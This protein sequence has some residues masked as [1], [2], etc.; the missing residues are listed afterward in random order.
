MEHL[1]EPRER[2]AHDELGHTEV[3]PGVARVLVGV[4]VATLV[5]VFAVDAPR[6]PSFGSLLAE[7][8]NDC[9]LQAFERRLEDE[10][11]LASRL[12]PHVQAALALLGAGNEQT[13][14]GRDGWL[15][16]RAGFDYATGPGFL[17]PARMRARVEDADT[18]AST[19]AP[20]PV[21]AIASL[22]EQLAER[23][24]ALIVMPTPVKAVVHPERL[25]A[26]YDAQAAAVQ[27]PSWPAFV[28]ALAERG[29]EVFDP[30]PLLAAADSYLATDTHW[31]ADAMARVARALTAEIEE[32]VEFA[33]PPSSFAQS[34]D[35]VEN[36]G[37]LT[38]MLSLPE[39]QTR[40][41]PERV[42]TAPVT[43]SPGADAGAA[44]VLLLGDSFSNVYSSR[45]A[46]AQQVDGAALDWGESAGL[47]EQ[48]AFAL[49]RPVDRIVR[50]AG[51]SHATRDA[52][53]R[54]VARA[55]GEG[56]DRL[57]DVRVV[58]YQFAMRELAQGDWKEI[59]LAPPP[60]P[61]AHGHA[62]AAGPSLRRL[63]GTV[64]ARSEVPRPGTVPYRDAVFAVHLRDVE[65]AGE[66]GATPPAEVVVYLFG[67]RDDRWT[68]AAGWKP[69]ES[70]ELAVR[71]W[72]DPGVQQRYASY[73]RTELDD[74]DLLI[75]PSF[76]AEPAAG[77]GRTE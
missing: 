62:E 69:G 56:R 44:E 18:C 73:N 11:A 9:T 16:H 21:A 63:R 67:M 28:A 37:D 31:R 10:S 2:Q 4:F 19:P 29:V 12:R 20:D 47:A 72:D 48:L 54:E 66:G 6:G 45:E 57:A 35:E 14:L 71:A 76:W 32:Q 23:G 15:F 7:L 41:P 51:G 8:P 27:N 26:R 34:A 75:L 33:A 22:S 36:R 77:E 74:F 43:R 53:A 58:V 1:N 60:A 3:S 68:A 30:T 59:A 25:S 55:A 13:Y 40:F 5:L 50:N 24:V 49:Q 39:G 52:L 61:G 42:T 70:V 65:A 46:F 64:A 38:V 17:D